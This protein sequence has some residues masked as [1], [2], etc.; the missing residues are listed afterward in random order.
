L[1]GV[2]VAPAPGHG[3]WAASL[4]A[5]LRWELASLR[6]FLTLLVAI[7][8]LSGVG[9]AIGIGFFFQHI[10]V[11]AALFVATGLPTINLVTLGFLAGPQQIAGLKASGGYD[12]IRSLPMP[13]SAYVVSWCLVSLAAGAPAMVATLV[14]AAARYHLS[15]Q[16][17]ASLVPAVVLV[18]ATGAMLGLALGHAVDKP[19]LIQFVTQF[20][21][22]AV[23]GFCPM[24]LPAS[25]LPHWLETLNL[26]LPFEHMAVVVRAGLTTG[27]AS[28]VA[29]AYL[30]LAAWTV[31]CY[32]LVA[33]ALARRH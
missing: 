32:A 22:F 14:V 24:A 33:R 9:F 17:S 29:R 26:G 21:F 8:L 2:A 4:W 19:S 23:F 30:V 12:F 11:Q 20:F 25:Q 28:D 5:Q 3:S 31:A 10:P 6:V 13:T 1:I 15:Y 27:L 18:V 7:Q 16:V